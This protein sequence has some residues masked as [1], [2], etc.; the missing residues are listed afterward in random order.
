MPTSYANIGL[1]E[2]ISNTFE[3]KIPNYPKNR[4]MIFIS[5]EIR[6]FVRPNEQS[7]EVL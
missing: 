1:F 4:N 5:R 3:M 7:T 6:R 2:Y